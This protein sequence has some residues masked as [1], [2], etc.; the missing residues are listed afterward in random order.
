MDEAEKATDLGPTPDFDMDEPDFS[1]VG[2]MN[3]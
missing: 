3:G 1:I 2:L